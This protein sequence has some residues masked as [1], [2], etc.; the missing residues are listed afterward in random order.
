M[1]NEGLIVAPEQRSQI[2]ITLCSRAM[3]EYKEV[4]DWL[5]MPVA[6]LMRQKLEEHHESQA[7]ASILRRVR[8]VTSSKEEKD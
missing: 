1:E 4:A 3:E 2:T 8:G 7:F 5:G 6:T